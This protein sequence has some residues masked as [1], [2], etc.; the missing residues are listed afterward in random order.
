MFLQE[1]GEKWVDIDGFRTRYFEAGK[2]RPVVLVHGGTMG[3]AS[4]GANAEDFD[5]NFAEL[6][7][8]FRVI[9][10]DRLGQGYTDNPKRDDDWTMA[11]SVRHFAGFLKALGLGPYNVVGHSRGGYVV[12]RVTL[13]HPE[14]V[15]SCVVID[16]N[17]AAPGAG[18]N[19]IVFA[20]NP[21]KPGTLESSRWGYEKYSYKTDHVTDA[22]IAMKQKITDT[23]KNK[24]AIAKMK[25]E[26]L[27]HTRFLPDLMQDK[28]EFFMRL[29]TEGMKRPIL[30]VWGYNDPT[31]PLAL[32][33]RLY[34][35][36]AKRQLR[37]RL[38]ILNEAG[39][40]SFRERAPEF[41]RVVAE[42]IEGA[43]HGE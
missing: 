26:G 15:E 33:L 9:S 42:F 8:R 18:R 23:P 35:L 1:Y 14:L 11:A 3:D 34:D 29:E 21:Y 24:A 19:E 32:G 22:W 17:S 36:I 43:A 16:S 27:L 10:V 4:G 37:T 39:H 30:L 5:R 2:G 28:D 31:A 6:A 38:H 25:D 40:H 41:N 12:A 7:K 20:T 13:D